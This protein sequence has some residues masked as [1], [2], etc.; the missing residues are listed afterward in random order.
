MTD[1]ISYLH[2]DYIQVIKYDA[3]LSV[4]TR[5]YLLD[6]VYLYTFFLRKLKLIMEY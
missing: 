4:S 6:Y 2:S 3:F 1:I 5:K